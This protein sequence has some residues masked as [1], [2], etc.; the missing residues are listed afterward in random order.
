MLKLAIVVSLNRPMP[1]QQR[2]YKVGVL[3]VVNFWGTIE[4]MKPRLLYPHF[5]R[6]KK[7]GAQKPR[8]KTPRYCLWKER[9]LHPWDWDK[10]FWGTIC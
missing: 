5:P 9:S 3:P 6:D 1:Y 8:Y 10:P 4:P 7:H 2:R